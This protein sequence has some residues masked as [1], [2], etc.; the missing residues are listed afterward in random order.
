[1]L[2]PRGDSINDLHARFAARRKRGAKPA[3]SPVKHGGK[4]EGDKIDA[5]Q[6]GGAAERR[7]VPDGLRVY[8]SQASKPVL[9]RS[10][11]IELIVFICTLCI[12]VVYSI[13]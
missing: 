13:W 11:L 10:G 8:Q 9:D 7:P 5:G 4:S 1:M 3:G 12:L 2:R 6:A